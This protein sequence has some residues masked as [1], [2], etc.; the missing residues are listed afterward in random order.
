MADERAVIRAAR[1]ISK[2][3]NDAHRSKDTPDI[4]AIIDRIKSRVGGAEGLADMLLQDMNRVRGEGLT[5]AEKIHHTYDEQVIQRYHQM[6]LKFADRKDERLNASD[7]AGLSESDLKGMLSSVATDL[8]MNDKDLRKRLAIEAIKGDPD[9]LSSLLQQG[10]L[11]EPED[12][13]ASEEPVASDTEHDD[14]A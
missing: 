3:L 11:E 4:P 8:L 12:V 14:G 10:C 1:E 13:A 7:L 5:D 6:I 9:L 2:A